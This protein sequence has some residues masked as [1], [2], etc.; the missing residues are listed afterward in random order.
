MAPPLLDRG[1]LRR[2]ARGRPQHHP[3]PCRCQDR[4]PLRRGVAAGRAARDRE[5]DAVLG[6]AEAGGRDEAQ[7]LYHVPE[8]QRAQRG[9]R[10]RCFN[11]PRAPRRRGA[12]RKGQGCHLSSENRRISVVSRS[13]ATRMRARPACAISSTESNPARMT[14]RACVAVSSL[15]RTMMD[16]EKLAVDGCEA[17]I[18]CEDLPDLGFAGDRQGEGGRQPSRSGPPPG[19][20]WGA[21]SCCWRC[22]PG[23]RAELLAIEEIVPPMS[24]NATLLATNP[25]RS[26]SR[27]SS[28]PT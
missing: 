13:V 19:S 10:A 4:R 12:W 14:P 2:D 24:M 17:S 9:R 20:P 15:A 26:A 5:A 18:G 11:R 23:C 1:A 22:N 3:G 28:L 8:T 6:L 25:P 27:L 7:D 21:P 16:S